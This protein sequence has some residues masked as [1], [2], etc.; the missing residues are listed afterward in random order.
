[1][2]SDAVLALFFL[3]AARRIPPSSRL[4]DHFYTS[5]RRSHSLASIETIRAGDAPDLYNH[6]RKHSLSRDVPH[7]ALDPKLCPRFESVLAGPKMFPT[8]GSSNV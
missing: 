5:N 8:Y 3:V 7:G 4:F 6:W 2:E 1:M